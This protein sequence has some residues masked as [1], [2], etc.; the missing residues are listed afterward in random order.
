[1]ERRT[2]GKRSC[3]YYDTCGTQ[4][5]CARC[6]GYEKG[7]RAHKIKVSFGSEIDHNPNIVGLEHRC[8]NCGDWIYPTASHCL[9]CGYV[10][11]LEQEPVCGSNE[12]FR[13]NE[14]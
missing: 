1:M 2:G 6:K 11:V 8:S 4:E 7:H 5:N 10:F 14:Q 13:T 3:K 9:A 12:P